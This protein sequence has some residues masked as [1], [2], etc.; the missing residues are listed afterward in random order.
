MPSHQ[1]AQDT[2]AH[3]YRLLLVKDQA[4]AQELTERE[5]DSVRR[6]R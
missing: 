5:P 2:S 3:T 4:A 6:R 1:G